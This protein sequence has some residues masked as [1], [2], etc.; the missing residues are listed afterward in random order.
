MAKRV[1]KRDW[2]ALEKALKNVDRALKRIQDRDKAAALF[3][4]IGEA[5][6]IDNETEEI[7][8]DENG[9]PYTFSFTSTIESGDY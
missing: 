5:T 3:F 7:L 6:I 4:T 2:E 9:C 1:L 8:L